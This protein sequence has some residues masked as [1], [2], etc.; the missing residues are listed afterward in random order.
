MQAAMIDMRAARP[1]C[2][3]RA[4]VRWA[5]LGPLR[6]AS[7]CAFGNGHS[8]HF[9]G[10]GSGDVDRVKIRIDE[11]ANSLP[12]PP[13]DIGSSDFSIEFWITAAA[14]DNPAPAVSCGANANWGKG[15]ILLDRHRF[16]Q[17][18]RFGLSI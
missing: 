17:A 6:L 11:P 15:H 10:T 3:R 16:G 7:A 9:F 18:R 4:R 12:G 2:R 13:A 8:L 14:V 1:Q 5:A